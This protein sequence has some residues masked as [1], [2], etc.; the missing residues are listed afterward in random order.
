M[1]LVVEMNSIAR[2]SQTDRTIASQ[3]LSN[4]EIWPPIGAQASRR[5]R[6]STC[7]IVTP[8]TTRATAVQNSIENPADHA[9]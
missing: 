3:R 5:C 6:L 7:I 9:N 4:V 8:V 2:R 1:V